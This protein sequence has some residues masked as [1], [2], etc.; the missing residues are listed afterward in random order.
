MNLKDL[1]GEGKFLPTTVA[2]DTFGR[3]YQ[4]QNIGYIKDS[5]G[6]RQKVCVCRGCSTK[7][8]ITYIKYRSSPTCKCTDV[9][10]DQMIRCISKTSS[11]YKTWPKLQQKL[12]PWIAVKNAF[13]TGGRYD[14]T[15]I[16]PACLSD[17]TY[18]KSN[19]NVGYIGCDC[20]SRSRQTEAYIHGVYDKTSLIA[21]KFGITSNSAMRLK[22]QNSKCVYDVQHLLTYTFPDVVSCKKAERE[23]KT[24]LVCGLI[25]KDYMSDGWSETTS[26]QNIEG[27]VRIYEKYGG[28]QINEH[29]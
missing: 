23:C 27:V 15:V 11:E 12:L 1:V 22:Q 8:Q 2:E 6:N 3:C 13:K 7:D 17:R 10:T 24:E 16:C 26:A 19:L 20:N 9:I 4:Y 5:R 18:H 14:V 21:I 29:H 28:T 25:S